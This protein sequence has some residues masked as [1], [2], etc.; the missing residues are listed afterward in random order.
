MAVIFSKTAT[1]GRRLVHPQDLDA[2]PFRLR[3]GFGSDDRNAMIS[4]ATYGS[5]CTSSIATQKRMSLLGMP[6]TR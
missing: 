2:V 5:D 6:C 1:I 3:R 4:A